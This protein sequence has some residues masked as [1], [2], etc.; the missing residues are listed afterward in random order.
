MACKHCAPPERAANGR[1]WTSYNETATLALSRLPDETAHAIVA[2]PPYGTGANGTASR[3]AP[4]STKYQNSE[5]KNKLPDFDGDSLLPEAWQALLREVLAQ[6]Y[7]VAKPGADLLLFCDWRSMP[8]LLG[9]VGAARFN[10]RSC[11]TW[12]KGRG[13][14][15]NRNGF[16]SQ[17]EF[18][19]HA[20]KPGKLER[21][22]DVY[23]DGVLHYPT[24]QR[25][26]QHVTQKPVELMADLLRLVPAGGTVVDPFQGSGTTGVAAIAAGLAYI[27]CDSVEH[28]HQ[29]T[30]D[31]LTAAEAALPADGASRGLI[32]QPIGQTKE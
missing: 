4:T 22:Q 15:P 8:S 26:K 7:R 12:N 27:G 20:R 1:R 17:S 5:T 19:L 25:D 6:A 28:Y 30:V 3:L 23:L 32:E 9:L 16:R 10:L 2:D 13:A 31:R 14:R 24:I 18:I 29:V 21:G 11:V